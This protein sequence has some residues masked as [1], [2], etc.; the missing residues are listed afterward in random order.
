AAVHTDK[1]NPL[2]NKS[3]TAENGSVHTDSVK[4][5]PQESADEEE[6]PQRQEEEDKEELDIDLDLSTELSLTWGTSLG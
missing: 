5:E 4:A 1:V 3:A 6:K 2:K